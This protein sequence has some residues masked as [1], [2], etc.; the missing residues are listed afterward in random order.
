LRVDAG[1]VVRAGIDYSGLVGLHSM[2]WVYRLQ[3]VQ[4]PACSLTT[5]DVAGC[6]EATPVAFDNDPASHMLVAEVVLG[7]DLAVPAP[8]DVG[9]PA[10]DTS[11]S[12]SGGLRRGGGVLESMASRLSARR[13][14]LAGS[15]GSVVYGLTASYSSNFGSYTATP[16]AASASWSVGMQSGSFEWSYPV[17]T[18][19]TGWGSAPSLSLNYSS[20]A[21]DGVVSDGNTQPGLFGHGWS[22]SL[23]GY[24]ERS[25]RACSTDNGGWIWHDFCWFTDGTN[26]DH[27]SIVLNGQASKLVA[28]AANEWRLEFDPGWRVIRKYGAAGSADNDGE[29]F[30]V[31]TPDGTVYSFGA[32]ASANSTWALPVFANQSNEPCFNTTQTNSWCQQAW[33]WNLDKIADTNGNLTRFQYQRETNIYSRSL[34]P[35]WGTSYTRAGWLDYVDYGY[36]PAAGMSQPHGRI[37]FNM[38]NRCYSTTPSDGCQWYGGN[39]TPWYLD[40]PFATG[41]TSTDL[42]CLTTNC[43]KYAPSFWSKKSLESISSQFWNGTGWETIDKTGLT[44]DWPDPDGVFGNAQL[45]LRE[46]VRTGK[47]DSAPLSLPPVRFESNVSLFDNRADAITMMLWRI[48]AIANETGEV[49]SVTYGQPHGGAPCPQPSQGWMEN[50]QDCYPRFTV[51]GTSAGWG[52]FNKFVVTSVTRTDNATAGGTITPAPEQ[53]WIYYYL[54]PPAWRYDDDPLQTQ[55]SWNVWRGYNRVGVGFGGGAE[56]TVHYF[57]RGMYGATKGYLGI[58]NDTFVSNGVSIPDAN[59]LNGREYQVDVWNN[60]QVEAQTFSTYTSSAAYA[61]VWMVVPNTTTNATL[62]STG[63]LTTKVDQDFDGYGNLIYVKDYGDQATAAD[64]RCVLNGYVL[65]TTAWIVSKMSLS[66]TYPNA[67]CSIAWTEGSVFY[68]DGA[69]SSSATPV[70][71][72][73]TQTYEFNG[74]TWDATTT[75]A[76]DS[77]GRPTIV[78]GP[79][80]DVADTTITTYDATFGYPKTVMNALGQVTTIWSVDLGRLLPITVYDANSKGTTTYYD[81]L[82]RTSRVMAPWDATAETVLF[83]Y[84]TSSKTTPWSVKTS[85]TQDASTKLNSWVFYDGFGQPVQSQKAGPNGGIIVNSSVYSNRGLVIRQLPDYYAAGTPGTRLN[86][87]A[88][89]ATIR[90]QQAVYDSFQRPVG[91]TAYSNGVAKWA[92]TLGYNGWTTV[93]TS[94]NGDITYEIRNGRG[95]ISDVARPLAGVNYRTHYD[96]DRFGNMVTVLDPVNNT[97]T[98]IYDARNRLTSTTDPDQGLTTTTYDSASNIVTHTT[99]TGTVWTG[100][101][102]LNRPTQRRLNNSTGQMQARWVYDK[103]TEKGQ[104]DYEEAYTNGTLLMTTDTVGYDNR[105][106]PTGTR[107]T[108][109]TLSGWTDSGLAGSYQFDTAYDQADHPTSITYPGV[110]NSGLTASETVTTAY[111]ATGYPSTT[112][113]G[114]VSG[115]GYT[116]DGHLSTRTLGSAGNWVLNRFYTW[117]ATTGRLQHLRAEKAKPGNP[118]VGIQDLTYGY[119]P[120]GNVK[121]VQDAANAQTQCFNYDTW[122]RLIR[123]YTAP[124]TACATVATTVQGAYDKSYSYNTIG[125]LTSGPVG[126]YTY[127]SSKVHAPS[128]IGTTNYTYD[129]AGNRNLANAATGTDYTYAWDT[130]GRMTST[131]ATP[132]GTTSMIYGADRQRILREAPDGTVTLYL[133]GLVEITDPPTGSVVKATRFYNIA[134]TTV[135]YRDN[136]TANTALR[137]LAGDIQGSVGATLIASDGTNNQQLYDP[138]GNVRAGILPATEHGF[139]N[140]TKDTTTGLNYLNNRY[141]D[142]TTGTFLS[143]D[144]LVATTG[145]PY[146]YAAGNPTTLSDPSGLEPCSWCSSVETR[147]HGEGQAGLKM[148]LEEA[149]RTCFGGCGNDPYGSVAADDLTY[150][151]GRVIPAML[152]LDWAHCMLGGVVESC[153]VPDAPA[154]D[155]TGVYRR[156][157]YGKGSKTVQKFVDQPQTA[158]WCG[159]HLSTCSDVEALFEEAVD[160]GAEW[161]TIEENTGN[162]KMHGYWMALNSARTDRSDDFLREFGFAHELDGRDSWVDTARDLLNNE[163]GISIGN[164]LAG[165][166]NA[167]LIAAVEQ[168][169]QSGQLYCISGSSVSTC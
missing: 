5:P 156:A 9:A 128:S 113:G 146:L 17:P 46:I 2:D 44:M 100:Y 65:N 126:T 75:T 56:Y 18:A 110:A 103:A 165:G 109:A 42:E 153:G 60:N 51:V 78:D 20:G 160:R 36:N 166:S 151:E 131:T 150:L 130:L 97:T 163:V 101:D 48:D 117:D 152:D 35:A 8:V 137:F 7:D 29:Y 1:T 71:G 142:P 122:N 77:A 84:N 61:G 120:V 32:D 94:P 23:G 157:P 159:Q 112:S 143:V 57:H 10:T 164:G 15:A 45:W 72:N 27:L 99:G 89:A 95:Q 155:A 145:D 144:P 74:T 55:P 63:W 28:I 154:D 83:T 91:N 105:N 39:P 129:A 136:S 19:P 38:M 25:Y 132:G 140:Q 127:G 135:A 102:A 98:N 16:L 52:S 62:S 49:T 115:T 123:G 138:Y 93:I 121:T 66:V 92:T 70:K 118:T 73:L 141:L 14:A 33:R 24:I 13:L 64:D 85:V 58:R 111:T 106:R 139:L 88:S 119:D 37:K 21:V 41:S 31:T 116:N 114:Y 158:A 80:S 133:A 167:Q 168:A 96:Y 43:L 68:Y 108:V 162:A 81:S 104:L 86:P 161:R 169:L 4:L 87:T 134:G 148:A 12:V 76:Y 69:S 30:E 82:G 79:R 107:Y 47:P 125:N 6:T 90:E 50:T 53:K 149:R 147:H 11:G 124:T 59:E 3:L 67:T 54:D 40:S 22:M 26:F 34:T